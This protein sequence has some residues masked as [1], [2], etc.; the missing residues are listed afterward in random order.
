MLLRELFETPKSV[1]LGHLPM[2]IVLVIAIVIV[3]VI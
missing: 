3:I 2:C 1:F